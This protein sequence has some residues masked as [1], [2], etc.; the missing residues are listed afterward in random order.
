[1]IK[2]KSRDN[3]VDKRSKKRYTAIETKESER[4]TPCIGWAKPY[5]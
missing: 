5:A 2:L 4:A 1:M 3:S